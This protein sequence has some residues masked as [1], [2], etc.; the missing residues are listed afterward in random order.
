[1]RFKQ[2]P[3]KFGFQNPL[4]TEGTWLNRLLT[5][6]DGIQKQSAEQAAGVGVISP[7][8]KTAAVDAFKNADGSLKTGAELIKA[9]DAT[10]ISLKETNDILT[11]TQDAL[12]DLLVLQK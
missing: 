6:G 1:M 9:T 5:A 7:E 11:E 12:I 3:G 10:N 2:V 4:T 8:G